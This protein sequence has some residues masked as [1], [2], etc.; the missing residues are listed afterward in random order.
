MAGDDVQLTE[1]KFRAVEDFV[2]PTNKSVYLK[3]LS[4]TIRLGNFVLA[5]KAA[6]WYTQ[7]KI[8]FLDMN[9]AGM[10]GMASSESGVAG[11]GE[12]T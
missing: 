12:V 4:Y 8:E 10:S 3:G 1:I 7:G 6:A 9:G 11:K 5:D 2:D